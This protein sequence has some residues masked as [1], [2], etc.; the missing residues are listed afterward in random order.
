MELTSL[1][2]CEP[3]SQSLGSSSNPTCTQINMPGRN[4]KLACKG[5]WNEARSDAC[6][7]PDRCHACLRELF[8]GGR[9][10]QSTRG[11]NPSRALFNGNFLLHS[12]PRRSE[13]VEMIG[14]VYYSHL[15]NRLRHFHLKKLW[16]QTTTSLF[17]ASVVAPLS[18]LYSL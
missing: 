1:H 9:R 12:I 18:P 4:T 13:T 17:S 10:T 5:F 3:Q 11:Q 8:K 2:G 14:V 15:Q 16:A 7:T 6:L